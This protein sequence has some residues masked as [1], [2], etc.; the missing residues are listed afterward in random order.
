MVLSTLSGELVDDTIAGSNAR[1]LSQALAP[2]S[3]VDLTTVD[4]RYVEV[5]GRG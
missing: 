2:F 5:G 3:A 1:R 4:D